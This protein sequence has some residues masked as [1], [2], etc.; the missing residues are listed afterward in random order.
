MSRNLSKDELVRT[1]SIRIN[2]SHLSPFVNPWRQRKRREAC[3]LGMLAVVGTYA[4][5]IGYEPIL[6]FVA[7]LGAV[8]LLLSGSIAFFL[9]Q[10]R[11]ALAD[12][13]YQNN[14]SPKIA[15]RLGIILGLVCTPILLRLAVAFT[16]SAA[17]WE[18]VWLT[19]F[20]FAAI[21]LA[22]FGWRER[23][24]GLSVIC[25]GFLVLFTAAS[26][27]EIAAVWCA[28]FWAMICL[29]WLVANHWE[30]LDQ[31]MSHSV[32]R[33]PMLRL[34]SMLLGVALALLTALIAWGQVGG[35]AR[36]SWGF[37]P[38][39]GGNE[40][41]DEAA[42]SGVGNGDAIVAAEQHAATFGA[43][44][45]NVF[46]DSDQPSLFDMFDD[47]LGEPFRPK[48][49]ERAV[50]LKQQETSDLEGRPG[51]S[52]SGGQSFPI[53][54]HKA[55]PPSKAKSDNSDVVLRWIG[56][57]GSRLAM[58]RFNVFDGVSW[59]ASGTVPPQQLEHRKLNDR[60][61]FFLTGSFDSAIHRKTY[62]QAVKVMRLKSPRIP[63]PSQVAGVSIKDVDRSDFFSISFD[64]SIFMPGRTSIPAQ[65]NIRMVSWG[66]DEATLFQIDRFSY[67][68]LE[69]GDIQFQESGDAAEDTGQSVQRTSAGVKE[70]ERIA[71]E[72]S[73][74]ELSDWKAVKKIVAYLRSEFEFD[75]AIDC[76]LE[77]P[78][79]EFYQ[80]RRGGD[81]MFATAACVML[82]ALGIHSR[83]TTG[84]YA[85]PDN[86]KLADG[87]TSIYRDDAHVWLEVNVAGD[88]WIPVE[89][90]PGYEQPK[91]NSSFLRFASQV[92]WATLPYLGAVACLLIAVWFS[93]VI[94]G[95]LVCLL[96]WYL[97]ALCSPRL[98]LRVWAKSIDFKCRLARLPRPMGVP[99]RRWIKNICSA[100][101]EI[102]EKVDACFDQL[103]A[104]VFGG[105]PSKGFSDNKIAG[106]LIRQLNVR[107][108]VKC[109]Q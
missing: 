40:Y 36:L 50:A 100:D 48:Q 96:A 7:E 22:L 97:A 65:T 103:D 98:R 59:Y 92:F 90:T 84:F 15:G 1:H 10:N 5:R 70:F 14:E 82:R 42:R 30:R 45:S 64:G 93:R 76:G 66:V 44:D 68:R 9:K 49:S 56:P 32:R 109:H 35:S 61:W 43:V 26:A 11:K 77:D 99:Q 58:E 108:L 38:T 72:L 4:V 28:I 75:R 81:H 18:M 19:S 87:E 104:I 20:G 54:R 101:K 2:T 37:M 107:F 88:V 24:V 6:Q 27:D 60:D 39:S 89:P 13:R 78:L 55:N 102:S 52:G 3:L 47:T 71:R 86:C 29:W 105:R 23:D 8:L 62:E 51:E 91:F 53:A 74:G 57:T 83:L 69:R 17:A 73:S 67:S 12:A 95:E 85:D 34:G 16:G 33:L 41:G 80:Q 25:S 106:E 63:A 79:N 46:L 31:C 21:G 94:W